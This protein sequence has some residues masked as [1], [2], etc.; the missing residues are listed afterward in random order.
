MPRY[1]VIAFDGK[2]IS[3]DYPDELTE[4]QQQWAGDQ[5]ALKMPFEPESTGDISTG[6]NTGVDGDL[7]AG[8]DSIT[9]I[10]PVSITTALSFI[11]AA[12]VGYGL[13]KVITVKGLAS[14]PID[15]GR[16]WM[17]W[18]V[19]IISLIPTT[20]PSFF[21]HLDANSFVLWLM[22]IVFFGAVAFITGWIYGK[23]F[24]KKQ[25]IISDP[26]QINHVVEE[27]P[28][29]ATNEEQINSNDPANSTTSAQ[30]E[31]FWAQALD[32]FEGT[33]R[34]PGLWAKSFA[35]AQG[36]DALTKANYLKQRTTELLIER[37]QVL[38]RKAGLEATAEHRIAVAIG[39][40]VSVGCRVEGNEKSGWRILSLKEKSRGESWRAK[41][42]DELES[43]ARAAK[44]L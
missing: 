17:A 35:D 10:L 27:K 24:G 26:A 9:G 33:S 31:E 5:L 11:L 43:F 40:I 41:T 37:N 15:Y 4:E 3:F 20:L 29:E 7:A 19:F 1:T 14:S 30:E 21:Q 23:L 28:H 22:G 16:M 18:M 2:P 34:R 8:W 38:K 6:L 25:E 39:S 44:S 42:L 12:A 36:D 32:E 13:Y